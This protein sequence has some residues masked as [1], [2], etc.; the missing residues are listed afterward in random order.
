MVSRQQHLHSG[1]LFARRKRSR[2]CISVASPKAAPDHDRQQSSARS[3]K[4]NHR[5]T[6]LQGD[7]R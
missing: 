2:F 6:H 7:G 1:T 4:A 3:G 5:N